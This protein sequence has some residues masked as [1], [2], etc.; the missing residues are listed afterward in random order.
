MDKRKKKGRLLFVHIFALVSLSMM[1]F[2][3]FVAAQEYNRFRTF[4][5][6]N[7]S[8]DN[9]HPR[10]SGGIYSV[11]G[12][13]GEQLWLVYDSKLDSGNTEI[14]TSV[15]FRDENFW[16]DPLRL[17]DNVFRDEYPVVKHVNENT[18][19]VWQTNRRDNFDL[20]FSVFDGNNWKEPEFITDS[21]SD[22]IHPELLVHQIYEYPQ[23]DTVV[24]ILVW[25]R[26]QKLYWNQYS[27][28]GWN[29]PKAVTNDSTNQTNPFL[30]GFENTISMAWE[31]N[32][33]GNVDIFGSWLD[34]ETNEWVVPIQLTESEF[35]DR[36]P[37]LVQ[38]YQEMGLIWQSNRDGDFDLY[39]RGWR[40]DKDSILLS[41]P[42]SLTEND[43]SDVDAYT[44]LIPHG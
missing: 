31:R 23:T 24:V 38:G 37:S 26:D 43:S 40:Q 35:E 15:R 6:S 5:F 36:N 41:D 10:F 19:V 11:W 3:S 20:M 14:F 34:S 22:D 44:L 2:K 33:Y 4:H 16:R 9:R 29:L 18:I 42:V 21:K 1:V 30:F 32:K 8:S 17:T 39:S 12:D 13:A 7:N 28:A 27:E 25:E